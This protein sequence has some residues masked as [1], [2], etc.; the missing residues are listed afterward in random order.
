MIT[1]DDIKNMQGLVIEL[2]EGLDKKKLE[3]SD[4]GLDPTIKIAHSCTCMM[5]VDLIEEKLV[6]EDK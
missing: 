1:K 2:I 6:K 3:V 4:E 5:L